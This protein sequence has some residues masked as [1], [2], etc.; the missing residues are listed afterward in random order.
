MSNL[1]YENKQRELRFE[2][3][4]GKVYY[5]APSG[6]P[7]HNKTINNICRI[8]GNYLKGKPC[9]VYSDNMDVILEEKINVIQ[10]DVKIICNPDILRDIRQGASAI[11]GAP[12]LAVEV[13]SPSTRK[14]DM[15]YKMNLYARFGVKEYWLVD[16]DANSVDIYL[17]KGDNKYELAESYTYYPPDKYNR[18]ADEDKEKV[19]TEFKTSIFDDL[20]IQLKDVFDKIY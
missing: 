13:L 20:V 2:I 15:G 14:R 12:D 11:N 9:E 4:D 8:F 10:P 6:A 7:N 19:V 16:T 17:L 18:L 3:L 5:Y 1:A